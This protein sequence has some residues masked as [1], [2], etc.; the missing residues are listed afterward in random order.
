MGGGFLVIAF[1]YKL[2]KKTESYI[3]AARTSVSIAKEMENELTAIRGLTF[4][5]LVNKSDVWL[6]S[7]KNR[8]MKFIIYLERARAKANSPEEE[9]LVQQISAL[10]TNYEQNIITSAS[11]VKTGNISK[12][13]AL[14]A[15]SAQDLFSTIQ[16]KSNQYIK[17][18]KSAETLYELE[19]AKTNSIILKTMV[20]LGI[21]GIVA[22]L[23]LGWLLTRML[24]GPINQ[25]VLTIRSATGETVLERFKLPHGG[26]L[27]ELG[28]RVKDL[29]DRINQANE[30]LNRNRELLQYSNK[31][32]TLGKIAP[33]I[34]HEIRNPLAAIKMLVYSIREEHNLPDSIKEDLDIISSEIDR[35]E[36]FTKDFLKFAKPADP[37]FTLV[38]PTDSLVEV[39]QLLKPRLKKNSIQLIDNASVN[40]AYVMADVGHLKQLYMNIILNAVEVMPKNGQL[41]ID[42]SII[43]NCQNDKVLAHTDFLRI[44]FN[45]SGPG[46]P[47]AIMKT[48][49]EPFIRGSEQGVG[50]GLSISQGIATTHGGWISAE[51]KEHEKG[52]IFHIFLPIKS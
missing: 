1:S 49:F 38:N 48:L 34:A 18:N 51:N 44:S 43:T 16:D 32:A 5:Y 47:E 37:I 12:A 27:D 52:A 23:L 20:S 2:Q 6:D 50:L 9:R 7:M 3:E 25:L 41:L 8:Q 36:G 26:E 42:A 31:Y 33:T 19:I 22:G 28:N 14:I 40:T 13:N 15:H 46:I 21:G 30:D 39:I 17:L 24:F 45:D 4:T 10:F 29:I 11:L 35:M